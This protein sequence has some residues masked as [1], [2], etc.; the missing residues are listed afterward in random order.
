DGTVVAVGIDLIAADNTGVI[1]LYTRSRTDVWSFSQTV[2]SSDGVASD[3]SGWSVA[4]SNNGQYLLV[5]SPNYPGN[6]KVYEFVRRGQIWLEENTFVPSG[7]NNYFG[8]SIAI[9]GDGT[10]ALIGANDG[11]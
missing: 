1:Y 4:L 7:T 9:S 2:V 11:V 10:E 8:V 3:Q 6:G 5:G